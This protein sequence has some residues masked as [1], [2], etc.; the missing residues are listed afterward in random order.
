MK[1]VFLKSFEKDLKKI[2]DK[3]I[4]KKVVDFIFNIEG[5]KTLYDVQNIV[6]MKGHNFA[7]R[8]KIENYR[9]GFYSSN[10]IVQIAR[11]VKRND[12]YKVFPT[13]NK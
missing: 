10:N 8:F 7:Y 1:I 6:K 3:T 4:K 9:I 5:A 12:I 13:K 11:I 2:K